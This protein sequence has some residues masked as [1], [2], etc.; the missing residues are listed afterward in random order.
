MLPTGKHDDWVWP[1]SYIPRHWTAFEG[2]PPRQLAGSADPNG[3]LDI[4]ARGTWSLAWPFH[5]TFYTH[6]GW[7][8]AIGIRYDYNDLYYN[9]PRFTLKH[10]E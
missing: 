7:M 10:Y 3:H 1:L 6:G 8:F 9:W 2:K 5:F 4:T